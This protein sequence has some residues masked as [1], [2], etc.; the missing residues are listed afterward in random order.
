MTLSKKPLVQAIAIV[1]GVFLAT[2]L[3]DVSAQQALA[4][5]LTFHASFD[6]GADADFGL[7][8]KRVYTAPTYKNLDAAQ[9]G[10]HNPDVSIVP[11][12]GRYGSALEFKA[13]NTAAIF[14]PAEKN[15]DYRQ[16]GWN[17]TVSF[18]LNLNPDEDLTGFA[19][20]I[21]LTDKDYN[22]AALWVD[23]TGNDK[24]RH[25]RLGAFGD[26]KAWNPDNVRGQTNPLFLR[27]IVAVTTPPF[28]RGTWTH[29]V[30]TFAGLNGPQPGSARF[31]LN[32]KL[33]GSTEP[34]PEPF[35]W[36]LSRAKIRLGVNYAGLFDD[37]SVFN[38][39]LSESEVQTIYGLKAGV[40]TLH[41]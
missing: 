3:V 23:F 24:P 41:R 17:G 38:R 2:L 40:S 21:Q 12:K 18:W 34:I 27:H 8:D 5:A 7:G 36:D 14:Y 9:A 29:V 39:A 28:A 15:V 35:T 16:G 25:A 22:D 11:G 19:D 37:L 4:T 10:L 1:C 32:G 33:Q 20:P 30:F 26:L 6:N 13:K 31:F